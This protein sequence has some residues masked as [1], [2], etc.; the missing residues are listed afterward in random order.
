MRIFV[1]TTNHEHPSLTWDAL[2]SSLAMNTKRT[3]PYQSLRECV[4]AFAQNVTWVSESKKHE[5]AVHRIS[6]YI[7]CWCMRARKCMR[8]L[9]LR[10]CHPLFLLIF[11]TAWTGQDSHQTITINKKREQETRTLKK[12][13][14]SDL[15]PLVHLQST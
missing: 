11:S 14:R 1:I 9:P 7:F 5:N 13:V 10:I 12:Q 4:Q 6:L 3:R 15:L 8:V 2:I